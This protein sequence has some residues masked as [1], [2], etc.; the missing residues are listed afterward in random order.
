MAKIRHLASL[1]MLICIERFLNFSPIGENPEWSP[2]NLTQGNFR[3]YW[4]RTDGTNERQRFAAIQRLMQ[5]DLRLRRVLNF[6]PVGITAEWLPKDLTEWNRQ[7]FGRF[8]NFSTP[9]LNP[10]W[11][12]NK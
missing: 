11:M 8:L 12:P 2:K 6:M 3:S 4:G 5:E 7:T 9:V 10:E 1:I